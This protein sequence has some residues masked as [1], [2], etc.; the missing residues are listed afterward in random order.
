MRKLFPDKPTEAYSE[1]T[2]LILEWRLKTIMA[3]L[4]QICQNGYLLSH[5][6]R[7][8][9]KNAIVIYKE[10]NKK[11]T[12]INE[13]GVKVWKPVL[14]ELNAQGNNSEGFKVIMTTNIFSKSLKIR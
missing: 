7:N 14:A 8:E 10:R 12:K 5:Q 3:I 6:F 1:K 4:E 9:I 2:T 11:I 13:K